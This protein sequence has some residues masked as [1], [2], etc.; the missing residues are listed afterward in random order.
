MSSK[1]TPAPWSN[2][3]DAFGKPIICQQYDF[4][5]SSAE[6]PNEEWQANCRLVSAAPDLLS[7]LIEMVEVHDEP[8]RIDHHGCCQSH[9]L[10]DVNDGGCRVANAR[11]AIAK[12]TGE[13]HE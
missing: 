13:R 10:D 12:A 8:C 9:F 1:H 11:A 3:L 4:Q 7:C 5:L 6:E 2:G